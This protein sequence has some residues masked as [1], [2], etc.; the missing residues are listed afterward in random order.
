MHALYRVLFILALA[1]LMLSLAACQPLQAIP[2]AEKV[3]LYETF[4]LTLT[5]AEPGDNPFGEFPQFSFRCGDEVFTFEGF[6]DGDGEG[7]Q[8]G[9]VWKARFMPDKVGTWHYSWQFRN[10]RGRGTFECIPRVNPLAHGH[11]K[12]DGRYLRCDDGTPFHM[13]EG[14]WF[15]YPNL[16]KGCPPSNQSD[17]DQD[18]Y[19]DQTIEDYL[20]YCAATGHNAVLF[21]VA[22]FPLNDDRLTWDL[23]QLARYDRLINYAASKGIYVILNFFDT[24]GR[25]LGSPCEYSTDSTKQVLDPWHSNHLEE[26]QQYIRYFVARWAGYWNVLWE[27][28]NECEHYPNNGDDFV[29]LA[30]SKYLP[31]IRAVD[32]YHIPIGL[33]EQLWLPA[34][35]DI[36]FLHQT[37]RLPD[38][39]WQRPTIMNELVF[40]GISGRGLY[41]D[42]VIRDPKERLGYR[43]SFWRMFTYGGSGCG[44]ATWLSLAEPLNQAVRNVM[45]DHK[46]LADLLADL[47]VDFNLMYPDVSA[48]IDGP[49]SFSCRAT[50][51]QEYVA[52]FLLDPGESVPAGRITLNLLPGDYRAL[53]L[54][55][56]TGKVLATRKLTS[57]GKFLK[58][59]H[60]AFT[61]DIVLRITAERLLS[62]GEK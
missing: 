22:S 33:S 21:K 3:P 14:K 28:G 54:N 16:H 32:P 47:K 2:S 7:G 61:E 8:S 30:N 29:E 42:A 23:S 5:G 38:R 25:K 6:Y 24:W 9:D 44:E 31:W 39:S 1:S 36:G 40:G 10:H 12:R 60:P 53:W 13:V 46:R 26:T 49:G 43:R 45:L 15:S 55:P 34:K 57:E 37:S 50:P 59:V 20:D 19:D 27:L 52:Y 4:T 48:I 56:A 18:Y 17:A 11:V 62:E 58:L 35:V 51:G 41:E